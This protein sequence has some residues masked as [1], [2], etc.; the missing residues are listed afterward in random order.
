MGT[1]YTPGLTVSADQIVRKTRRLPLK[2]EVLIK[3]GDQVDPSSVVART[4]LPGALQTIKVAEKLGVEV[5]EVENLLKVKVGDAIHKGDLIAESKG[6]FGLFKGTVH[7]DCEGTYES[8]SEISGNLFVREAPIPIEITAYM[9]GKVVEIIEGEGAIIEARGAMIQGIFGIGGERLGTIR[10]AVNSP[11]EILDRSQI[12]SEDAGKILI[13]GA[14]VTFDAI[15]AA[16]EVGVLG[17]IA[18]AVKDVDITQYLGYDIGVAITG[19]EPIPLTIIATEGF[20]ILAMA[21]TTFDLF[22]KLEG[23]QAS[24]NGATQIRA[25]VIR[26]EVIVPEAVPPTGPVHVR[27]SSVLNI[28]TPIRII[29]EPYF[30]KI[31][32]VT[33]L[34][35]ELQVVESGTEVRVL[36]ARLSDGSNVTVPR[37]NV[38][39]IAN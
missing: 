37:A 36:K 21:T 18:G 9:R 10:V 8:L 38:E 14:G 22:K 2:G 13:G 29:R 6:L 20:G 25:G 27:E 4:E 1:A 34:P 19:Q 35:P 30:G 7:A 12:K 17:L 33:E 31:G 5:R 26:P 24:V 3:L 15:K 11:D 32:E 23:K 28:G 16:E 39:I